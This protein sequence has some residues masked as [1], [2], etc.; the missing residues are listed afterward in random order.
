MAHYKCPITT[1]NVNFEGAVWDIIPQA[2][3]H[4]DGSHKMVLSEEDI[5]KIIEKQARGESVD[6]FLPKKEPEV[7]VKEE[8]PEPPSV[9][10]MQKNIKHY[11]WWKK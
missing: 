5:P 10:S 1:C 7:I 6:E 3:S 8:V 11:D 4:G 2:I 9:A